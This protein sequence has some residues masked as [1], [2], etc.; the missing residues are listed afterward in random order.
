M[1]RPSLV[2]WLTCAVAVL[3]HPA[4]GTR[5]L[6]AQQIGLVETFA[7]AEDRAKVLQE[8]IPGSEE[9]FYY[10]CLHYQ[11]QGQFAE[12]EAMLQQW[13][14]T[15]PPNELFQQMRLRQ[16]LLTY[17]TQPAQT[18]EFLR[19]ELQPQLDH[20]PPQADRA[21]DLPTALD[22]EQL[23]RARLL[24][25][26]LAASPNLQNITDAGLVWML[27]RELTIDQ[28]RVLLQRLTRVDLPGLMPH[29]LRELKARD[30]RG[31]NAFP[32][33]AQLTLAQRRSLVESLPSLLENDAFVRQ[34]LWR[35]HPGD[36]EPLE[37]VTVQR[38]H[39]QRLEDFS[40]SL[41]PSQNSLK[42][43][44]L[45]QRLALDASQEIF[46]RDRFERYLALPRQRPHYSEQFLIAQQRTPLVELNADYSAETRLPPIRDDQ[47][48]IREYLEHFFRTEDSI[49]RFAQW[50]DRAYLDRVLTETKI[51]HGIGPSGPWYAKLTPAE[52]KELRDRIVLRFAGSSARHYQSTD[53]VKLTVDVKNVPKLIVRIYQLNPSN[54]YRKN[55][56]P[57][58]TDLDLDGLVANAER[59][60]EYTTPAERQHRELI[61]LP[62]C[63]GRGAWVVDLLGG[64]LRS[65]ALIIKGQLR[66]TQVLTDAGHEF[67]IH[68]EAGKPV[69]SAHLEL[70]TRTFRPDDRGAILVPYAEAEATLPILLADGAVASV[71]LFTHRRESYALELGLLVESQNLLAGSQGTL[72]LRP[73]LF[74]NGQIMPIGNLE[75]AQLTIVTTDQDGTQSIQVVSAPALTA[76]SEW[77]HPFLVPQ[78]LSSVQVTLIGKVLAVSRNAREPVAASQTLS[79][80]GTAAST[81]IA[82]FYW[83]QNAEGYRLQVRGRNGEPIARLPVSLQ[84]SLGELQQPTTVLLATDEQGQITLGALEQVRSVKA[85]AEQIP[86]R[87]FG[88]PRNFAQWPPAIFLRDGESLSLPWADGA[89]SGP[90]GVQDYALLEIRAGQVAVELNSLVRM[91]DGQIAIGPLEPGHYSLTNH[92]DGTTVEVRV[93]RGEPHQGFSV[94]PAQTLQL[95]RKSLAAIEKSEIREEKLRLRVV[96][97]LGSARVHFLATAFVEDPLFA[98][99]F[100]VSQP[101]LSRRA[102]SPASNYYIDALKL[103]EEYQYILQRQFATRYPGNLLTQPSLLLNPWDTA[104]TVNATL[105]AKTGDLPPPMSPAPMGADPDRLGRLAEKQSGADEPS[106]FLEFLNDSAILL[107]NRTPDADGWVELP[108]AD[109]Q[110]Y[111]TVTAVLV[112]GLG[113]VSQT[114]ALPQSGVPL[115]DLRLAE[116]F[117]EGQRLAQQ[118][119]VKPIAA[120]VATDLGD[121]RTT[122]VQVYAS[123][124]DLFR[125][126]QTLLPS[127]EW[128]PFRVLSRWHQ[129]ELKEKQRAYSELACH[130]LHLFLYQKDRPFF[131]QV[132][133]P[134]FSNK[135][136][137]QLID[138]YL[139]DQDLGRYRDLWQVGRLNTLERI[140]LAERIP[141]LQAG[142]RKWLRDHLE[143]NPIS[144]EQRSRKFLT[145][146]AGSALDIGSGLNFPGEP[147]GIP[148]LEAEALSES[149][150]FNLQLSDPFRAPGGETAAREQEEKR[151]SAP[152]HY[153]EA[154]EMHRA[155]GALGGMGGGGMADRPSAAASPGAD[156]MAL[157]LAVEESLD[158]ASGLSRRRLDLRRE[159]FFQSLDS[160]REWAE[161][162]FHRTRIQAQGLAVIP[163]GPLWMDLAEHG[164]LDDF[165]SADVHLASNTLSEML[166]S[167]ALIDLP[168]EAP[169]TQLTIE[170]G[171]WMLTSPSRCLAFVET[172]EEVSDKVEGSQVLVGQELYLSAA[173]TYPADLQQPVS[174]ETLVRGIGYRANVVVTNPSEVKQTISVLTQIPQGAL[175]LEAGKI[176]DSQ[177]VELEPY[178]TQ[179][180]QYTFY[181]PQAGEFTHYGAQVNSVAGHLASA[182]SQRLRVLDQPAGQDQQAW[183][184]IAQWGTSEQVLEFLKTKNLQR[185]SLALIAFRMRDRAFFEACLAELESQGIFEANLWAYAIVHDDEARLA[186]W[187][188][189]QETLI[190]KLGP[191]LNSPLARVDSADRYDYEHLDYRPLVNARQ[192]QLGPQRTILND[193]LLAQ[194]QRLLQRIAYQPKLVDRDKLALTY[195]L[196]LQNRVGEALQQFDTVAAE[197]LSERIQYDYLDAYLDFFRGRYERAAGI[198]ERYAEYG[199]SRWR[200]L[201]AQIRLQVQQREAMLAGTMPPLEIGSASDVTDP[202]Q[203]LLLDARQAQQGTLAST[204]PALELTLR[205]GKLLCTY[206]N[207]EQLE[208]RYYWM[209]IELL[210]SRNPFVQQDGGAAVAIQPNRVETI[211][212]KEERGKRELPIPADFANRNVLVEVSAGA[213]MRTQIVYSNSMDATVVDAFGRLQVTSGE[214]QPVEKAYVK[215][216]ARHHGG[217]VRFFKDGYTDLRGQFDYASLS[218][219]D[220]D[221][222]ER[223]AIL[224]IHPERGALIRE[225]AP[226][227]R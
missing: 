35:L 22:P 204:T 150:R 154:A 62:E 149:N 27:N 134:H 24:D 169:K 148:A 217:E 151:K 99:R 225:V 165:L 178:S 188:S 138:R 197:Q 60:L 200:D 127:A 192:H 166:V 54:L 212:L 103:D 179:Q 42:A 94:G 46:D 167:L 105:Q 159:Q 12:A 177:T 47:P 67:R 211:E 203:R 65:R 141:T 26:A 157:G 209:D 96:N 58:S 184:Y 69:P 5:P 52:Q 139:S 223:F 108:L 215:V 205:D 72:I 11:N 84:F 68:D 147:F 39:L 128:E 7:L 40:A 92:R 41:P 106:R 48:L 16:R 124:A 50:L 163:P 118:Q 181:F 107:A 182:P 8:L 82:D 28:T 33:H 164:S 45:H 57:V 226:P 6:R 161:S 14:N 144:P 77:L 81:Q 120:G 101:P 25:Q 100:R 222:V 98:S 214:G 170:Q 195:Y 207:I 202:V 79:I 13:S 131:D 176:V 213:L 21:K 156:G 90:D 218:T 160:T 32:I 102:F 152:T 17:P 43:G 194:Y 34:Y 74:G 23:N 117:P 201:F 10:H 168:L 83:L 64:G 219:N 19:N 146:L 113:L 36:D 145:A 87:S 122:R 86:E 227:K 189:H 93:N 186:Q 123:V 174:G 187:L 220:L 125:L 171:R 130:E 85:S 53:S 221:S 180:L 66:S 110:G 143:A 158:K 216:Y 73:R 49:D 61:P 76:D 9:Y 15:V 135:Y 55:G 1:S 121:A 210:F 20:A 63:D 89:G 162:Q 196:L 59:T 183:S 109:L 51:L 80:N 38:E 44:V 104:S 175:P 37:S 95:S 153:A 30:S 193:R 172:I 4:S 56:K 198:A 18:L 88:L 115:A 206:Q 116:S 224:V 173:F 112:D 136:E 199:G 140:L 132:V 191:V 126:Y 133:R 3:V 185:V 29:I 142:T 2:T 155:G 70:G 111:Q 119:R 71:E 75:G 114:I 31:W 129:L 208:V 137:S 78:R 190:G 97:A 91:T